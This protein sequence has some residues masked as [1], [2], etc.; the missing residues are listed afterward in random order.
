MKRVQKQAKNMYEILDIL[1][2]SGNKSAVKQKDAGC[3]AVYALL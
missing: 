1:S 2:N 3:D